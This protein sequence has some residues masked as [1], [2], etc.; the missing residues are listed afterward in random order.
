ML[1]R[2]F[3]FFVATYPAAY[4]GQVPSFLAAP[5]APSQQTKEGSCSM[6]VLLSSI[7][8]VLKLAK[9]MHF[10]AIPVIS[11]TCTGL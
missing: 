7:F 8:L 4:A 2:R 6:H 11:E 3:C 9:R 5:V 10:S 1:E